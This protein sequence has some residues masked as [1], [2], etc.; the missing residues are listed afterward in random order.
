MDNQLK[1]W[2]VRGHNKAGLCVWQGDVLAEYEDEALSHVHELL[3]GGVFLIAKIEWSAEPATGRA[4][5][6]T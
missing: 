6:I 4:R 2:R 5:M 3:A 1:L